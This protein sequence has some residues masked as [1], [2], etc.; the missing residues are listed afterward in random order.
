MKTILIP[1]FTILI[2]VFA[3]AQSVQSDINGVF[4]RGT[5]PLP[6]GYVPVGKSDWTPEGPF[7]GDVLDLAADHLQPGR[8]IAAAGTPYIRNSDEEPWQVIETLASM[9]PS[10]IHCVAASDDGYFYAAGY[11]SSGYIYYSSDGG[12]TWTQKYTGYNAGITRLVT[13]PD[14][15]ATLWITYSGL[16]GASSNKPVARSIDHG[17]TW[18]HFDLTSLFPVGWGCVDVAVNSGNPGYIVAVGSEGISNGSVAFSFDD[19]NSW[20]IKTNG[21]PA[22]RPIN[23]V[24]I[25]NGKVYICGGQLFGGNYM[26]VYMSN[27]WGDTWSNL[28]ALFPLKVENDLVVHPDDE[29]I[30]YVATEGDGVYYTQ[31][32]G[33][34]WNYTS[35][36]MGDNGS[37]RKLLIDPADPGKIWAGFLSLGVGYSADGGATWEP[38]VFGISS[39]SLNGIEVFPEESEPILCSFEAENSG[40][41]YIRN[42]DKWNLVEGLPATRYSA[43]SIGIDGTLY[44]WSNGP[45]TVASEGLYRSV[46]GGVTW[47]NMGPDIGPVFETQI[48]T[49]S[50]SRINPGLIFIGGNNFGVNGWASMIYR[51]TDGG[52][53]WENVFQGP[54]MDAVRYVHIAVGTNDQVVFASFKSE[55]ATGGF[56]KSTDGGI[57]WTNISNGLPEARWFGAIVSSSLAPENIW[58]GLGGYGNVS[59]TVYYSPD[60]G[61][62]WEPT[63]LSLGNYCKINDLFIDEIGGKDENWVYAATSSQGVYRTGIWVTNWEPFNSGIPIMQISDFSGSYSNP[64]LDKAIMAATYG[65]SAYS[66]VFWIH[67]TGVEEMNS[68][69]CTVRLSPNPASSNGKVRIT[70]YDETITQLRLVSGT[71]NELKS[72]R[73]TGNRRFIEINQPAAGMYYLYWTNGSESGLEKLLVY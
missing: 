37:V 35:M 34:S 16:L 62:T 47:E 53:T 39:L 17:Q 31:N 29:N 49:I 46:D 5:S 38:S 27:D 68:K 30:I 64:A 15:P 57:T 50:L 66:T 71:G 18:E 10:G 56:L 36:G 2:T 14:D 60:W 59:G 9:V 13:V 65:S 6:A 25:S 20:E 41:C 42:N 22:N 8:M 24:T 19:G 72:W 61:E 51:S 43:V 55:N 23:S 28:S 73:I 40:G 63:G 1:L 7:G 44:A 11:Y 70:L 48:W 12:E 26:G 54:D 3:A 67:T 45:T 21:L 4:P 58:G 33:A 32:G 69:P 52:E